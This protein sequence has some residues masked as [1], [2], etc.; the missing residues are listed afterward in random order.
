[1][2]KGRKIAISLWSRSFEPM[3]RGREN[4][5]RGVTAEMKARI[6]LVNAGGTAEFSPC[7]FYKRAGRFFVIRPRDEI[8]T[9]LKKFNETFFGGKI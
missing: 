2:R 6:F 8:Y 3:F 4:R 7:A 1:M 9:I 5:N